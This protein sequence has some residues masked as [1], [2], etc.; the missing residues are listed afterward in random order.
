MDTAFAVV[1][2]ALS[3]ALYF[4]TIPKML[5]VFREKSLNNFNPMPIIVMVLNAVAWALYGIHV[6]R[7]V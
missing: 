3:N 2:V 4:N 6:R 1:G 5:T 7:R